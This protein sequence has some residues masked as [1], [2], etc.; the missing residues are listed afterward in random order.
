M[1]HAFRFSTDTSY[2][3]LI[4][5]VCCMPHSYHPPL[6]DYYS[7]NWQT[8]Q[9]IKLLIIKFPTASIYFSLL[10]PNILLAPCSQTPSTYVLLLMQEAKFYAYTK[11]EVKTINLCY[12]NHVLE[13]RQ[14]LLNW[15]RAVIHCIQSASNVENSHIISNRIPQKVHNEK[16]RGRFRDV[17]QQ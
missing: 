7:N 2:A 15:I 16:Y 5:D 10:G 13:E 1:F 8:V 9:L 4:S 12:L 17:I 14:K 3:F 6:F 11:Q